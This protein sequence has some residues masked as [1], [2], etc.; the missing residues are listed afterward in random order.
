MT[1]TDTVTPGANVVEVRVP[2]VTM[3]CDSEPCQA[4]WEYETATLALLALRGRSLHCPTCGAL[5][6][7]QSADINALRKVAEREMVRR[8]DTTPVTKRPVRSVP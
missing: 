2:E 6:W 5:K 7:L 8:T 3:T 1:E 4:S